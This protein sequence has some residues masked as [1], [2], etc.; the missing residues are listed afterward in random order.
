MQVRPERIKTK[1]A[2]S[3]E[4]FRLLYQERFAYP[5]LEYPQEGQVRQPSL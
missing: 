4:C 3:I 2:G 1:E 5:H